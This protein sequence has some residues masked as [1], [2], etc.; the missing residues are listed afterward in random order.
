[1]CINIFV[2]YTAMISLD[3]CM[4]LIKSTRNL[5]KYITNKQKVYKKK[6]KPPISKVVDVVFFFGNLK[7][8]SF[9]LLRFNQILLD[10]H[11]R[12]WHWELYVYS[13]ISVRLTRT[14]KSSSNMVRVKV[15]VKIVKNRRINVTQ[16]TYSLHR[17]I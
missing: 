2:L 14:V 11:T 13:N 5:H 16:N 9:S 4:H 7:A 12:R 10:K 8:N 17:I 3:I 15:H 6:K 1:M